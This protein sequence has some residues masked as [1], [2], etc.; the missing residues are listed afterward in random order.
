[1]VKSIADYGCILIQPQS[2]REVADLSESNSS[3]ASIDAII[4]S[5]LVNLP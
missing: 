5:L 2:G 1:A 4:E 3:L